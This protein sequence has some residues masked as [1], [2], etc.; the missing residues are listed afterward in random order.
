MERFSKLIIEATDYND[1]KEIKKYRN[2]A[3][4]K[5]GEW[6][7]ENIELKSIINRL[8]ADKKN[9]I[10]ELEKIKEALQQRQTNETN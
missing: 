3:I 5:K 9:M 6:I 7:R 1:N 8:M 4:K 2:I 10:I